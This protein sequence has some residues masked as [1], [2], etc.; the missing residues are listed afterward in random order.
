MALKSNDKRERRSI[1]LKGYDYSCAGAYFV[2]ICSHKRE[3]IFGEIVDGVMQLNEYGQIVHSEWLNTA[4]VRP[5]VVLEVFI[6][7]PNHLHGI[8]ALTDVDRHIVGATRRVAPTV[9]LYTTSRPTGPASGSLGAIIGQFK[10][11]A[12][13]RINR[14][15]NT[16]GLPVWQR[17]Y[18]EHVIRNESEL[19]RAREYIVN[20]PLQWDLDRE[21]PVGATRRVA[22]TLP[23]NNPI[24]MG[25]VQ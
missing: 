22:P 1:R 7:M 16:P 21:N 4:V 23:L 5:N 8:I 13:K 17:N 15:R 6:I 12:S 10:P 9:R 14:L 3:C 25:I 2:T 24:E 18:Y 11:A 19:S 20:N